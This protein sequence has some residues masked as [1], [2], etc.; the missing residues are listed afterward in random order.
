MGC[1][2]RQRDVPGEA[3][4]GRQSLAADSDEMDG[5]LKHVRVILG[6]DAISPP[7]TGIGRY[8]QSLARG[9]KRHPGIAAAR[10][11]AHGRWV[12]QPAALLNP[13]LPLNFLRRHVPFR[14]WARRAYHAVNDA[15]SRAKLAAYRDW[16][17]HAPNYI[18]PEFAMRAVCTIHD[19]SHLHMPEHH[20]RDRVEYLLRELPRTLERAAH[21][22]TVSEFVRAEVIAEFGLAPEQVTAVP[23]G[24]EP[25]YHPREA[26][27][28]DAAL[29]R[30]GLVHGGYLLAVA[31]LEPRKNL[32]RLLDAYAR[33][34]PALRRAFPLVLVG[35]RGWRN[36]ALL[37]RVARMQ[38]QGELRWLGYVA[39]GELPFMYA[40]AAAFAFPSLYEGF[41]L[42]VLEA[43]ASGV[44]VLTSNRAS[45]PEVAGD[46]AILVEPEDIVAMTEGLERMLT[47]MAWRESA[48]TR[49]IERARAFTWE[50]CVDR[51]VA[52]YGKVD[53]A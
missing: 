20:P 19:L 41:G 47:D 4:V 44:P 8:V 7:L 31:T 50:A 1:Q 38:A 14:R 33:L 11:Y 53:S 40:G 43:M 35:G 25:T 42:P 32:E 29:A 48:A 18:A 30:H 10:Y 36:E 27:A 26:G 2:V 49:G 16:L 39:E 52:I 15:V 9:L 23:L 51:T 24:V 45:L 12:A 46:A 22:I 17:F 3:A 21:V 34:S 6:V 28:L 37:A 13:R 5:D